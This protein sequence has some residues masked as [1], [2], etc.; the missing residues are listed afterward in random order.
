MSEGCQRDSTRQKWNYS[1]QNGFAYF[2]L[3]LQDCSSSEEY[4]IAAALLP[5]TTAFYRVSFYC[6]PLLFCIFFYITYVVKMGKGKTGD[7]WWVGKFILKFINVNGNHQIDCYGHYFRRTFIDVG[8][9]WLRCTPRTKC[10]LYDG[11]ENCHWI[12][13]SH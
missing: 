7:T 11:L 12:L 1:A 6:K 9:L 3:C 10:R 8:S 13:F 2:L 5:L 4:S